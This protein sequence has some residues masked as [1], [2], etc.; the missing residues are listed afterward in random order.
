MSLF[1]PE[2]PTLPWKD[3]LKLLRKVAPKRSPL[4]IL[5]RVRASCDGEY[6]TFL[7]TDLDKAVRVRT[8]CDEV[9]GTYI[10]DLAFL[11]AG[12]P[13][14]KC[15]SHHHVADF[16]EVPEPSD[17]AET[18]LAHW[19]P[20]MVDVSFA[21]SVEQTRLSLQ[22]VAVQ[23][24]GITATDG[25]RAA[26]RGVETGASEF[27]VPKPTIDLIAGIKGSVESVSV[28]YL[29]NKAWFRYPW[30]TVATKLVEGPFPNWRMVA[31]KAW[32][33]EAEFPRETWIRWLKQCPNLGIG[34][35][36]KNPMMGRFYLE[37][38]SGEV[39]ASFYHGTVGEIQIDRLSSPGKNFRAAWN[40]DY[41][42]ESMAHVPGATVTVAGNQETQATMFLTHSG[43]IDILMPLRRGE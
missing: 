13:W 29:G 12:L 22:G 43:N 21:C 8:L 3:T 31:P 42:R 6:A 11:V 1:A 18:L 15:L 37:R 27:I 7:A 34:P 5:Q 4:A 19:I 16:P 23:A 40:P 28:D 30:G 38:V 26:H 32:A 9:P 36:K 33:W 25:H 17:K 41:F 14:A 39:R 35:D 2:L 20:A 24:S 10:V